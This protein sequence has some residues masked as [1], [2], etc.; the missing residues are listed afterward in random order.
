[1]GQKFRDM[2]AIAELSTEPLSNHT[3]IVTATRD[4]IWLILKIMNSLLSTNA[5][6]EHWSSGEARN[7]Q[8][9]YT[10]VREG[11]IR[12][13]SK[14]IDLGD[15]FTLCRPSAPC[16]CDS[17]SKFMISLMPRPHSH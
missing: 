12:S 8:P 10:T 2:L 3:M 13:G 5:Q 14:Q 1:M 16:T 11:R 9:I 7:L 15:A 17:G 6:K 4:V